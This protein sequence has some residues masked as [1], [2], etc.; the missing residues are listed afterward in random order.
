MMPFTG[1]KDFQDMGDS[2]PPETKKRDPK[3]AAAFVVKPGTRAKWE[4]AVFEA[5]E[6]L[7]MTDEQ[8]A[9]MF[10]PQVKTPK[11]VT[12][13]VAKTN[14][15]EKSRKRKLSP[16]N[17]EPAAKQSRKENVRKRFFTIR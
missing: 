13:K 1:V 2:L 8:R 6:V 14:S 4:T 9:E 16:S 7:S 10:R 11:A 15:K 5:T 3:Y 17:N 12:P